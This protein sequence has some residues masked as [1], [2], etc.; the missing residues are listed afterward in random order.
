MLYWLEIGSKVRRQIERLPG[1]LHRR[2]KRTIAALCENP[3][4]AF[5]QELRDRP[6]RF[7]IQI[8]SDCRIFYRIN[9]EQLVVLVLRGGKKKGPEFYDE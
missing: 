6:G 1:H 9:E 5:A 3:R 4:P 7:R 8:D 2:V